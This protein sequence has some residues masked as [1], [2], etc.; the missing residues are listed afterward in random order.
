MTN[1]G[2]DAREDRAYALGVRACLNRLYAAGARR[3]EH[4]QAWED[5]EAMQRNRMAALYGK[6]RGEAAET[7][8]NCLD[9]DWA[10]RLF[11]SQAATYRALSSGHRDEAS[12]SPSGKCGGE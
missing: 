2:A 7:G 11:A 12:R 10:D 6:R 1:E 3:D 9:G 8:F 4:Y 5:C